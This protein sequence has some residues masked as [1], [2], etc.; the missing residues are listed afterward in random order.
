EDLSF[1]DFDVV[2]R[3]TLGAPDPVP[4]HVKRVIEILPDITPG[5]AVKFPAVHP[6]K[7]KPRIFA[8]KK[9]V[10]GHHR[11]ECA[12]REAVSAKTGCNK[13]LAV[14]FADERQAVICFDHLSEP[15]MLHLGGG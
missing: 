10:A 5:A 3:I 11:G 1:A 2:R 12:E 13:L 6:E 9:T 8:A 4:H 15:A 14:V 7:I